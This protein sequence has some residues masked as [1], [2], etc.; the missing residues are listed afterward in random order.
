MDRP[1]D[2]QPCLDALPVAALLL[3]P[4]GIVAANALAQDLLGREAAGMG[5]RIIAVADLHE[6]GAALAVLDAGEGHLLEVAVGPLRGG[7]RVV[8]LRTV[9]ADVPVR[10]RLERRLEFE[11]LLT[12][13]SAALMRSGDARLDGEIEAVLGNVGGFFDV[14]RAYVFLIDEAAGT[15]SNTHEWTAPG[16]SREAQNLQHVPLDTFPWLLER[17]RSD[18][19]F[20]YDRVED[21]PPQAQAERREF[22]REGIRSILIVPLWSGAR[23]RGFIGFDAVRRHVAWNDSYVVGLRLLA[24]MLSGALDARALARQLSR[25]AMHDALT[26]LPNRAYLSQRFQP[27]SACRPGTL[28]GVVD[29]DDFKRVNDGHGHAA[30]DAVLR[31]LGRRLTDALGPEAVVARL[32]GDEFVVVQ[33]DPSEPAARL[34]ARLVG[35]AAHPFEVAGTSQAIGISLGMVEARG[36]TCL[37]VLLE[38]ADAAM[39]RAKATG[40]NRW[41]LAGPDPAT[42]PE[43]DALVD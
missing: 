10:Q 27:G 38:R 40:K 13:S 2:L 15:Q 25:Q 30:G 11:R 17:L 14:D 4:P 39:Y 8:L 18:A 35:I 21:L 20:G 36:P 34:A 28:V 16:V 3:G 29:V 22:E 5:A 33:P 41:V 43:L 19:V 31:E 12:R 32:G 24:Q 9:D 1:V 6:P 37:E 42:E 26:G 23:L 7:H